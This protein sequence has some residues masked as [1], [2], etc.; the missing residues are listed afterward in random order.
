LSYISAIQTS[1]ITR[2]TSTSKANFSIASHIARVIR[3]ATVMDSISFSVC[4]FH[5]ANKRKRFKY[6]SWFELSSKVNYL[7]KGISSREKAKLNILA[8]AADYKQ[9]KSSDFVKGLE[10]THAKNTVYKYLKEL[11]NERLMEMKPG[12]PEESFR[13]RFL[14]PEKA[15]NKVEK[16][17]L[18]K[19][20][21][22]RV[23][24]FDE[25]MLRQLP[26]FLDS[27]TKGEEFWVWLP[28]INN[29]E[30]IIK[31]KSTMKILRQD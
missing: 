2:G 18:R 13:P 8:L 21:D 14:I 22:D 26:G 19:E 11:V 25:G 4:M 17:L 20:I 30:K 15:K 6:G 7:A 12:S 23:D 29:P 28:D 9:H 3:V 1:T 27:L 16:L 24:S 31:Y 5:L 10:G